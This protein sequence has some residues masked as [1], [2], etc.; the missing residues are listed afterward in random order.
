MV[1]TYKASV[2][3]VV[4][5]VTGESPD[6]WGAITVRL[7]VEY[8]EPTSVHHLADVIQHV[9]DTLVFSLTGKAPE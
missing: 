7:A 3:E 5:T 2:S 9:T 6:D 4:P 1:N 8:P